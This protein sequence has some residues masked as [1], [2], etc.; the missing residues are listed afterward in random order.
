MQSSK[1]GGECLRGFHYSRALRITGS[2]ARSDQKVDM[3]LGLENANNLTE[4][5]F[6][7]TE[8]SGE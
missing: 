5:L 1:I 3:P 8:V 2:D 6:S 4:L 7:S